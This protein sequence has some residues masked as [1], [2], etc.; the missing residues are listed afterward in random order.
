MDL[1]VDARL[2]LEDHSSLVRGPHLRDIPNALS[3]RF[4][5]GHRH[6]SSKG[7]V[8]LVRGYKGARGEAEVRWAKG[9]PR[10]KQFR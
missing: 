2:R 6:A 7:L 5:E 9:I 4:P 3:V 10:T 1:L 8:D